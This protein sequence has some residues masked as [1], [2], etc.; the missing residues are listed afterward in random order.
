VHGD[1]HLR[2]V[3]SPSVNVEMAASAPADM[4]FAARLSQRIVMRLN[5]KRAT[6]F[7]LSEWLPLTWIRVA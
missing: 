3:E 7:A 4:R 1:E 2:P 6:P 5:C